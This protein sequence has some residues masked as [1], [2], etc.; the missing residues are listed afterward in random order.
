MSAPSYHCQICGVDMAIARIRTPNEPPSAAWNIDGANYVSWMKY[1][2][3]D[4]AEDRD[5][6]DCTTID[7]TP[8]DPQVFEW[9]T[10]PIWPEDDDSDDPDWVPDDQS[11]ADSEPLEYDSEAESG[12]DDSSSETTEDH[13][14]TDGLYSVSNL[15]NQPR[16]ERLPHGTWYNN[17]VFYT[18]TREAPLLCDFPEQ[19]GRKIPHEHIASPSCQSLRGING[20]VLSVEQI[21]NCRNSRLI[22]PKR[23][24]W[25]LGAE[26]ELLEKDSLFFLSGETNGSN[27]AQGN[28]WT[29]WR[30]FYPSRH[31]VQELTTTWDC[32]NNGVID[33]DETLPIAV[34]SYCL[35]IYAKTSFRKLGHA[36]LDGLWHWREIEDNPNG[37]GISES[38]IPALGPEVSGAREVWYYPW[39]H[40]PGDEWLVANPVEVPGSE[41]LWSF[42]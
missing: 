36:N 39:H 29:A 16:P 22:I 14:N 21:K 30:S 10:L 15:C 7:R 28:H 9:E 24:N 20:H 32:I 31:G 40:F 42:A 27:A 37:H 38:K 18:G 25:E 4:V 8:A 6:K 13:D 5:C 35:D 12:S 19:D 26:D 23:A 41:M 1:P 2:F 11:C 34:H 3:N 33:S 17:K